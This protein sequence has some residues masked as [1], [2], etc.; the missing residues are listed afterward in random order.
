MHPSFNTAQF[1]A[2]LSKKFDARLIKCQH[3]YAHIVSLM[4]ENSVEKIVGISCDGVGYGSDGRAWGGEILVS[5]FRN[6][7]RVG[8]LMPQLMPGGD[9]AVNYPARMAA[10]ILSREYPT[11]ELR[12]ILR[13]ISQGFRSEKEID[14]VLKQIEQKYNTPKTTSTGRVLDAI[15][16]LLGICYERTYEGEPAMK[17]EALAFKGRAIDM[18]V[19]IRN[20]GRYVLDTTEILDAVL[21]FKNKFKASDVAASAQKA[22]AEGLARIAIKVAKKEKIDV[23]GFS[24][25]VAY[26]DAIVRYTRKKIEKESL[27]FLTQT[28]VSC[29]DGGISL[30]QAVIAAYHF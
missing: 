28:K 3:H 13:E 19:I 20:E 6:F 23:V 25:G 17:L 10:G 2:E 29:G 8:S 27:K 22:I 26:N 30:G 21:Q 4:A 9:L 5:D 12:K 15:S 11:E 16:A 14:I 24:G 1:G 18:P 7:K